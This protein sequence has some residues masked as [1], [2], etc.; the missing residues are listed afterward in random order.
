MAPARGLV[1]GEGCRGKKYGRES[2]ADAGNFSLTVLF[3]FRVSTL[4]ACRLPSAPWAAPSS[5]AEDIMHLSLIYLAWRCFYL[6]QMFSV[7]RVTHCQ[8]R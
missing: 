6:F 3:V 4:Q 8:L 1:S 7:E 5:A 2:G